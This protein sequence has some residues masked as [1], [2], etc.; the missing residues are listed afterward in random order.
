MGTI[1]IRTAIDGDL[2]VVTVADSGG[3]I[4]AEVQSRIFDPFFTTK[5]VGHGSGQG[6]AIAR[7]AVHRHDGT[8]TFATSPAGTT[9]T[10]RVPVAGVT[11]TAHDDT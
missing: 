11:G 8:L 7:A 10:L 5:G 4:P 1:K 9:F 3:G 2:T 6:L